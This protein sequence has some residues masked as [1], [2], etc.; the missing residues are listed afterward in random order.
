[1]DPIAETVL[2]TAV[3]DGGQNPTFAGGPFDL[4]KGKTLYPVKAEWADESIILPGKIR[5]YVVSQDANLNITVTMYS[6]GEIQ[7]EDVGDVAATM[8]DA[9]AHDEL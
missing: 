5:L 4:G 2:A 8:R 3:R 6:L 9:V 1:M 7:E